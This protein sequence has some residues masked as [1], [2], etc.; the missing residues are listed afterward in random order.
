MLLHYYT[1]ETTNKRITHVTIR[2][3][4]CEMQV[5]ECPREFFFSNLPD[6][7]MS[8]HLAVG[9]SNALHN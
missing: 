6:E 7:K 8:R 2:C 9:D 1:I 5:H 3:G 4:D